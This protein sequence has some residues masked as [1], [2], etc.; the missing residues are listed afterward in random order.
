MHLIAITNDD[1][2]HSPGLRAVV[3]S[4]L[5]L[6]EVIVIAPSN[7]QTSAG[8]SFRGNKNEYFHKIN[9]RVRGRRID[10][11]HCDCSP[12]RVVLHASDAIFS[13]KKPNILISGIN[14]GENLGSNITISGTIGAALQGSSSRIPSLA[15]SIQTDIKD[16]CN[17]VELDWK[18]A[19]HFTHFFAKMILRKKMPRDVD[20]LNVNIPSAA[21]VKTPWQVTCLSRQPYFLNHLRNPSIKSRIGNAELI[22]GFN[23][24][25]LEPNSDILVFTKGMV[26]VTPL[27]MDMTSRG[28]L[29]HRHFEL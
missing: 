9:Y 22:H 25:T 24:R 12:A 15:V 6:G 19:R 29:S 13:D 14:Y 8:R 2:I 5:P 23:V 27:S 20:I 11:Y 3:E 17:H 21:T 16:H 1:G 10:A 18:V 26:S 7:Q 4:V 28:V